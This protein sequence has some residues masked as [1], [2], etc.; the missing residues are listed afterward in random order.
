[1]KIM[2]L[3][4]NDPVPVGDDNTPMC[5]SYHIKGGCYNNCRRKAN[6][7]KALSAAE[8]HKLSNWIVDQTAKLKARF[9][10]P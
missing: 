9:N 7:E 10:T 3:L 6:H 4:G 2:E 1:V 5:L 8:K